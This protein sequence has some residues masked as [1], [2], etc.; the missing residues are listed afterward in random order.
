LWT[1]ARI[2]LLRSTT[3][4]DTLAWVEHLSATERRLQGYSEQ[5]IQ[6]EPGHAE[7]RLHAAIVDLADGE[8]D[9]ALEGRDEVRQLRQ[10][11]SSS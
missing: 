9:P 7:M 5:A 6:L 4:L 2:E 8:S 1:L 10:R 11:N 3:V